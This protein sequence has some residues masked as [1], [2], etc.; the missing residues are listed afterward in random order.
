MIKTPMKIQI[1][2]KDHDIKYW[3]ICVTNG[4]NDDHKDL[5]PVTTLVIGGDG[6]Y[7]TLD[8]TDSNGILVETMRRID[9]EWP[10]IEKI[11]LS[12]C[13]VSGCVVHGGR[14]VAD[15]GGFDREYI[16][17]AMKELLNV[18]SEVLKWNPRQFK[19]KPVFE[20]EEEEKKK[21]VESDDDEEE[22]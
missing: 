6:K 17:R 14:I 3:R 10:M 9:K 19:P 11:I 18:R 12:E 15:T 16:E 1:E 8:K 5:P 13:Y 4:N 7:D 2:A 20:L 21:D 22:Y